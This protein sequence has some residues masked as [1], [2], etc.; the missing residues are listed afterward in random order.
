MASSVPSLPFNLV[1]SLSSNPFPT[2]TC[3]G[4]L[5]LLARYL[6]ASPAL[7]QADGGAKGEGEL[8]VTAKL[9]RPARRNPE[10]WLKMLILSQLWPPS[11]CS[12]EQEGGERARRPFRARSRV[13]ST[14]HVISRHRGHVIS[15][16]YI[17]D[18]GFVHS[19]GIEQRKVESAVNEER[20][21]GAGD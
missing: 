13:L 15:S 20:Q 16:A 14:D 2:P 3:L 1:P 4:A 6:S 19:Q 18:S 9:P 10:F 8:F 5:A 7:S 12:D 11:A 17:L 21:S